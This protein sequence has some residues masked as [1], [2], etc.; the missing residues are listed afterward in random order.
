MAQR[1]LGEW[2]G[3]NYATALAA[4]YAQGNA[5]KIE[6]RPERWLTVDYGKFS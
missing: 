5:I 4:R 6:I 2:G 3:K 1:Y